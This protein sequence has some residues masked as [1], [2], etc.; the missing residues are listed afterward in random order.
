[1]GVYVDMDVC[2]CRC[3]WVWICVYVH[4]CRYGCIGVWESMHG[5]VDVHAGRCGS[6][7]VGVIV[8]VDFV[9]LVD[10]SENVGVDENMGVSY[11]MTMTR[12]V[13]IE[14]EKDNAGSMEAV[15]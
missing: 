1:M 7:G 9:M 3:L 13:G 15:T 5:G 4:A 12:N 14:V 8:D 6:M 10:V 2:G 11:V